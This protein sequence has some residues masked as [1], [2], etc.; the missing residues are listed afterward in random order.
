MREPRRL[1][2][3]S[4]YSQTTSNLP[5]S[6]FFVT[7]A[8]LWVETRPVATILQRGRVALTT[9]GVRIEREWGVSTVTEWGVFLQDLHS[10]TV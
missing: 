4:I 1:L 6:L 3:P 10:V 2:L 8:N 5:D 7:D 9:T